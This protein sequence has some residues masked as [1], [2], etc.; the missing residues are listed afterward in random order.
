MAANSSKGH[1]LPR[2]ISDIVIVG[3]GV[4]GCA[5]AV[6]FGK[7]GRTVVLLERSLAQPERIVGELLHP[8]G[9]HALH[10][11]GMGDCLKN[12]DAVPCHGYRVSYFN[13]TVNIPYPDDPNAPGER[14]KGCSFQHGRYI[15]NLRQAAA[16]APNVTV[17]GAKATDI[18]RD[19]RTGKVIGVLAYSA[20]DSRKA[21]EYYGSLTIVCDGYASTFR[22][23]YLPHKPSSQSKF[24]A[25]ELINAKL[26]EP[27]YGHVFLSDD[28]PILVYQISPRQTRI[29]LDVPTGL[30]SASPASGG[31]KAHMLNVVLPR[32]PSGCQNSFR[33]AVARGKFK[34]MPNSFLP[35]S[36]QKVPGLLFLGDALNMRHPLTGG[37]MTVAFND[38]LLIFKLLAPENVLS[39]DDSN[40]VLEQI[41]RFHWARKQGSSL[42]NILAMALYTLF[43]AKDTTLS[44]LKSGCFRYFQ[45]GGRCK[46]E[47]CGMLAG[48]IRSPCVLVY[49]FFAVAFY[50]VWLVLAEAPMWKIPY[51]VVTA[52]L[53]I[54]KACC[55]IGPYLIWE[56]MP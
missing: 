19:E 16:N 13:E 14:P 45:I 41:G 1:Q 7:Q 37:G 51:E 47:P 50:S 54:W 8:G 15:Q 53:I 29:F 34:S 3:G 31:I 27:Y 18:L 23:K 28:P 2:H 44:A 43:A 21:T 17:V 5:S 48:L 42:I 22:K 25:L 33:E 11:L 46:Q 12:I 39:L 35:P 40:A 9:V 24:W 49:H 38:V 10:S 26:P 56:L 20:G 32:L 6:A 4:A 52:T 36:Q 55:V 30:P